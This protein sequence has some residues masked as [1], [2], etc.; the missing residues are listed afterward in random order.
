M[1]DYVGDLTG[2]IS[3]IRNDFEQSNGVNTQAL[4]QVVEHQASEIDAKNNSEKERQN[5][6]SAIV[7][8]TKTDYRYSDASKQTYQD[9]KA[10][11]DYI[12]N[13]KQKHVEDDYIK[14]QVEA[15]VKSLRK[16]YFDG[17]NKELSQIKQNKKAFSENF[18]VKNPYDNPLTELLKRQDFNANLNAFSDAQL[19]SYVDGLNLD[20]LSNY[21]LNLLISK[22]RKVDS[23]LANRLV[24]YKM[25]QSRMKPYE[26]TETWKT[27]VSNE[28]NLNYLASQ[29]RI[30][31]IHRIQ[32]GNEDNE[33]KSIP[34]NAQMIINKAME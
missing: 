27:L 31:N 11:I 26:K 24:A 6:L 30:N 33:I 23:H 28:N 22:T 9:Y 21:E 13:A 7:N 25:E 1:S 34:L 3:N 5:K 2:K 14:N 17:I 4:N 18:E 32:V 10:I 15:K 8:S 20:D 16:T 19:T 12:K 29:N